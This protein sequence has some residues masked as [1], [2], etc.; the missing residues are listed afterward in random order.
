MINLKFLGTGSIDTTRPRNKLSKDYRRFATLL[1]DDRILIDP[2]EDV[3]EFENTFMLAG[4]LRDAHDVFITHSHIDRFSPL[5]LERLAKGG[6][7]RVYA[8]RTLEDEIRGIRGVEYVPLEPF[9]LIRLGDVSVVPLPAIHKTDDAHEIP[10]NF[11]IQKGEQTML[12]GLDG[13]FI[14]PSAWQVLSKV[15]LCCAILDCANANEPTDGRCTDHNNLETVGLIHRIMSDAGVCNEKTKIILSNI[16]T[17]RKR[18]I[19]EE[20]SEAVADLPYRIAYDGYFVS[21]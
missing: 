10:F 20:L 2:A 13:A 6:T 14:H 18:S 3:F 8:S 7:L 1:I 21:I 11:L 19:H 17:S 5:A 12:Y 16:P 15:E 9:S 4:L